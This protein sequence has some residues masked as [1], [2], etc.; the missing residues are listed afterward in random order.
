MA[1]G[2]SGNVTGRADHQ[3]LE[4]K[5]W[6]EKRGRWLYLNRLELARPSHPPSPSGALA[7]GAGLSPTTCAWEDPV[8]FKFGD[9]SPVK[10]L[11]PDPFRVRIWQPCYGEA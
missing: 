10:G 9:P 7:P 1:G 5:W 6:R 11:G 3:E 4:A 2:L 8:L